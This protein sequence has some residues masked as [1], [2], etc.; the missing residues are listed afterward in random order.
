M[1]VVGVTSAAK[2]MGCEVDELMLALSTRT[3]QAGNDSDFRRLT[4]QQ[5]IL[6]FARKSNLLFYF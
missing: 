2:L 3:I 4:L 5:V 1:F 6:L